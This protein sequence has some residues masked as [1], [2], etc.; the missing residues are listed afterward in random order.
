MSAARELLK[1]W[2]T[3]ALRRREQLRCH[4][5][6]ADA[7]LGATPDT[8]TSVEELRTTEANEI[9]RLQQLLWIRDAENKLRHAEAMTDFFRRLVRSEEIVVD[10]TQEKG[11]V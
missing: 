6:S 3:C 8:P 2:N 4:K 10:K 11:P 5:Q 9:L 7:I 1:F